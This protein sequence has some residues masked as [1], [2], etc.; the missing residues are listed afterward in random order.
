[1]RKTLC[2]YFGGKF[3]GLLM[4]RINPG[5][6]QI[7]QIYSPPLRFKNHPNILWKYLHHVALNLAVSF[8]S[9][10]ELGYVIGDVNSG[11]IHVDPQ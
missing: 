4:P 5:F 9:L 1:L 3:A 8:A 7:L 10:H 11:N 2:L 6:P